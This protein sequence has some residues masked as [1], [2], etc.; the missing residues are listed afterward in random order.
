MNK[1]E[2]MDLLG[3]NWQG[4]TLVELIIVIAIVSILA[5]VAVPSMMNQIREARRSEGA[6]HLLQLTL[7]QQAFRL[8]HL[9]YAKTDDLSLPSNKHFRY[10]VSK[11][12]ATEYVLVA[13]ALGEQKK[14]SACKKMSIDQ[15]MRKTPASCFD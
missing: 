13:E 5:T 8:T 3:L 1:A 11:S 9:T 10:F 4:M 12:S 6:T 15:S 7:Q 14:D 2:K